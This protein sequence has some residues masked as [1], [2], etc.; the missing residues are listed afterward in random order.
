[1][2]T[3]TSKQIT[4]YL[5]LSILIVGVLG[6]CLNIIVFLSLKTFRLN[7]CALFLIFM[8]FVNIGQLL[9]SLLSR[10]LISGFSI[11]LTET[12]FEY[13]K[14]RTYC[15]Q[16]CS[17]TSFTCMCF[18][19]V[20][21]FL[22]TSLRPN[23]QKYLTV[24]RACLLCIVSFIIWLLHGIPTLI[25]FSP[26]LSNRTG[27]ILCLAT[28]P[29]Y[30]QYMNYIYTL[31][32]IGLLPLVITVVFGSLAYWNVRQ[33]PY[34]AIPLVRRELDKQLTSMVLV[35][36]AHNV[37]VIVP[38]VSTLLVSTI[39]YVTIKSPNFRDVTLSNAT[40]GYIYYLYYASPF[41]IYVCVSKRFRQ[42]LLHVILGFA[43]KQTQQPAPIGLNQ[44]TPQNLAESC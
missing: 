16:V 14:F 20:E 18:A 23:W 37:L 1:M 15:L 11:N 13:C 41:Y 4:L 26:V 32:L 17:L 2:L 5:G 19:T 34:R 21:Q 6:G 38:Y 12:S 7:S 28:N 8:S 10:I 30:L 3:I 35:Q 25:W 43:R 36:V 27:T 33:I 39:Q 9:T 29:V 24:K 44:I 22:A 42:Q 31:I 40:T